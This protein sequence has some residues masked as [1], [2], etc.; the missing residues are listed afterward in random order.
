MAGSQTWLGGKKETGKKKVFISGIPTLKAGVKVKLAGDPGLGTI[1]KRKR[2]KAQTVVQPWKGV[3]TATGKR[4]LAEKSMKG[5]AAK[6]ILHTFKGKRL[7]TTAAKSR[8]EH[9]EFW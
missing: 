8:G 7:P 9:F 3:Q 6:M 4:G 2:K 1:R 5:K